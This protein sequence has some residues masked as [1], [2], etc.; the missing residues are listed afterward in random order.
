MGGVYG[1]REWGRE[2]STFVKISIVQLEEGKCRK[3]RRSFN[4]LASDTITFLAVQRRAH[5]HMNTQT[6]T[7]PYART[8]MHT[9]PHAHT[10]TCLL[11]F[12]IT[13]LLRHTGATLSEMHSG[14]GKT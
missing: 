11:V 10:P 1:E 8:H 5:S 13:K 9:H 2:W 14:N 6:C 12:A 4:R 3:W 7:H